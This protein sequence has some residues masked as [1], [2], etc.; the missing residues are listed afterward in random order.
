MG[1]CLK[2]EEFGIQKSILRWFRL[3]YPELD[4]LLVGYTGGI[5]LGMAA[6]VRAKQM[7]LRAGM[8]DLQLY[9]PVNSSPGMMLELKTKTG[10]LSQIQKEYHGKLRSQCYTI[11]VCYSFE[12]AI[13]E[14]G[15]YLSGY[16]PSKRQ[17]SK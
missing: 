14:I 17:V 1:H 8:P 15:K 11:V 6:R 2:Y 10:K 3:Q 9:V 5:N 4:G 7:G 13:N 16:K 12:E